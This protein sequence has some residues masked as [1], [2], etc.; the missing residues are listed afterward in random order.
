LPLPPDGVRVEAVL[1]DSVAVDGGKLH[2]QGAGWNLLLVDAI[3]AVHGRLGL[4]LLLHVPAGDG[5]EHRLE[6]RLEDP[7]GVEIPLVAAPP[8]APPAARRVGGSFTLDPPIEGSPL[9][10]QIFATGLNFD[11]V[12]LELAGRH[13]FVVAIDGADAVEAEFAVVL[14]QAG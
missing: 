5:S 11:G 12:P 3:P 13:R 1:A 4:G 6:V 9:G 7:E 14:R 8:G 10:R 2:V